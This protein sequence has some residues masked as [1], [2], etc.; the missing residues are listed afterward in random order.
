MGLHLSA[1]PGDHAG[2]RPQNSGKV[3]QMNCT[4]K[5][6]SAKSVRKLSFRG[7]ISFPQLSHV[8]TAC[9]GHWVSLPSSTDGLPDAREPPRKHSPL[10]TKE[11][12][13][14]P[15]GNINE[16]QRYTIE[17]TPISLGSL[18]PFRQDAVESKIG[19]NVP[20]TAVNRA[21]HCGSS[22]SCLQGLGCPP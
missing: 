4:L 6:T 3:E 20:S 15:G 16:S 11:Q 21:L 18:V 22:H 14:A 8:L 9:L 17:R 1:L 12:L 19:G 5:E 13:Q 7:H 10:E 2:Y